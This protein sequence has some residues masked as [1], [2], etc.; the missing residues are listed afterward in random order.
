MVDMI[1][2]V[3]YINSRMHFDAADFRPCQVLFVIDMVDM[4]VLNY[5]KYT[6]QMAYDTCLPAVMDITA[7]HD[8]MADVLFRPPLYLR[9]TDSVPLRL[10]S[11]FIIF[12]CPF[13]II[14]RLEIFSKGYAAVEMHLESEISQSSITHP[15]DQC[16]PTIPS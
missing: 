6:P 4:I 16:G 11:V 15:F 14:V 3:D 2:S 9:L 7:A 13:I 5:R 10:G 8:V 1:P 12:R